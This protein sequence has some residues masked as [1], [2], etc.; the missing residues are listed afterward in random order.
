M[1]AHHHSMSNL[2]AQLGKAPDQ[3]AIAHFIESNSP[4]DSAVHPPDATCWT[5]AQADFLREAILHDSE[6]TFVVDALNLRLHR[7]L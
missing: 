7:R 3:Q 2:F 4:L 5:P 1:E 6:W